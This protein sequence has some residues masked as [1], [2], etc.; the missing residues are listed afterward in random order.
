MSK[1]TVWTNSDGMDVGFGIRDSKN[2]NAGRVQ[3]T[4]NIEVMQYAFDYDVKDS[5]GTAPQS[6]SF[7]IPA[8]SVVLSSNFRVTTA[9]VGGTTASVGIM[10]AAG[11][12][13]DVAGFIAATA[14]ASLTAG[15]SIVGAG[16][17]M[18]KSV[19][20]ADAYMVV[21][22]VG[23]Y[24]AGAGIVTIEYARPMPSSA[25]PAPISGIV[26]TL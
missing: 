12:A 1:A 18:G 16:A 15:A 13:I 7:P 25:S 17:L 26:G 14:T 4:G 11:T 23:T 8:N 10:N 21:T 22:F 19:G 24:T 5:T 2:D 3:T 9:F 6:K 20:A